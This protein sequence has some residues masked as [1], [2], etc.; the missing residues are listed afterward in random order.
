M[1][2]Q[3][4]LLP[5]RNY[6]SWVRACRDYVMRYGANLT[7]DRGT[8]A[9]YMAPR[10][11]ISF[12]TSPRLRSEIG[13]LT[14]WFEEHHPGIRLDAIEAAGPD[15]LREALRIRLKAEDRYGQR[16]RPFYLLWPTDYPVITQKFGANPQIYTR[17]G[18]P[19]HEGVDFRALPYTNIYSCAEGE[20]YRVHRHPDTHAYGI[21]VRIR[22]SMGYRTVYGHLAEAR[23][24]EGDPVEAGQVI[25]KADS[26]G[27]STAAHLHLTLKQDGATARKETKYP[28]DVI[29]PTP[30]LVWPESGGAKSLPSPSWSAG[31][32]LIGVHG[33]VDG[34][35][36]EEDFGLIQRARVEAVKVDAKEPSTSIDRLRSLRPSMLL[37]ARL[38]VDPVGE[39]LAP[40]EFITRL[41]ED[42]KR[43]YEKGVRYFELQPSPNLH[44]AGWNRGWRGGAEFAKWYVALLRLLREA[45]PEAKFGFPGLSPG[46]PVSGWRDD[47]L[48]F[49]EAAEEAV[50]TADW[51]GV[52]CHW[53]EGNG[54]S[55]LQGGRRYVLYRERYPEK[56]LFVTEFNNPAPTVPVEEKAS[57][58]QEYFR[59]VREEPGLGAALLYPLAAEKGFEAVAWRTRERSGD[60]IAKVLGQ[61]DY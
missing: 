32:C 35:L 4:I 57:Q 38:A 19:G 8:A 61:R 51:L 46:G 43:L 21:H 50:A 5:E 27:A 47:D 12:P 1:D 36:G 13:D 2:F 54:L 53:T 48:Q 40:R 25:G 16:Q 18:M 56:L 41:G 3:I 23:V 7:S 14:A 9:Q 42:A 26:T 6:W 58:Y 33:R 39:N 28:K 55:E 11:V 20:V 44:L 15:E 49:L 59:M 52:H 29:D 60:T 24:S 22:H 10:Q 31:R 30:F 34:P 17:F 45:L 37:M